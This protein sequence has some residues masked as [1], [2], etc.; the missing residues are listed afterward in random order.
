MPK[1]YR[2]WAK[3]I[4]NI[5]QNLSAGWFGLAFITPNFIQIDGTQDFFVLTLDILFGILFLLL[6]VKIEQMLDL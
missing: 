2:P 3:T 6:S 5:L 4:S 1:K